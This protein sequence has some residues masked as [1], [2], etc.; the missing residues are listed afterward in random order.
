METLASILSGTIRQWFRNYGLHFI[1]ILL[2]YIQALQHA[3][4]ESRKE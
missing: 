4:E 2:S 3:H 1:R